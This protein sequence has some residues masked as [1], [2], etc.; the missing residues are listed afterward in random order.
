MSKYKRAELAVLLGTDYLDNV[1]GVGIK[2]AVQLIDTSR[3]LSEVVRK[4]ELDFNLT[5]NLP[6]MYS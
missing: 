6:K 5:Q 4:M 2:K 1:K 3:N